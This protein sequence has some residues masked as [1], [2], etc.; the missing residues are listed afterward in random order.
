MEFYKIIT[1][2][3]F[4]F[5][6]ALS[7][8]GILTYFKNKAYRNNQPFRYLM[9]FLITVYAFG[10]YSMWSNVFF[11]LYI[12]SSEDENKLLVL[13]G[14][15]TLLGTPFLIVGMIMLVL[16]AVSLLRKKLRAMILAGIAL[17]IIVIVMIYLTYQRFE[18]LLNVRQTYALIVIS[19]TLFIC[20]LLSVSQV[21]YLNKKQKSLLVLLLLLPVV[22]HAPLFIDIQIIPGLELLFIF[23]FFLSNTA[24]ALYFAYTASLPAPLVSAK[25]EEAPSIEQFMAEFS[26]TSRESDVI[27]EIYKGKTNREIAEALFVTTQTIKDHT[28]RIYQKTNVKNRTQLASLLRNYHNKQKL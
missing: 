25:R 18:F 5:C 22:I 7:A 23:L 27:L 2:T 17:S 9:Y 15:L 13:S 6:L 28:H 3:C 19:T 16:W 26:I 14:Y 11:R 10:F 1:W 21:N 4:L 8:I 20:L 12:H 24:I